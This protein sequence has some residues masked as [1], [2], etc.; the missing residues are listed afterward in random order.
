MRLLIHEAAD[1]EPADR[2]AADYEPADYGPADYEAADYEAAAVTIAVVALLRPCMCGMCRRC[3]CRRLAAC[4][5]REFRPPREA[6]VSSFLCNKWRFA[7]DQQEDLIVAPFPYSSKSSGSGGS[8][9]LFDVRRGGCYREIDVAPSGVAAADGMPFE[10]FG[11][12][13]LLPHAAYDMAD[14]PLF[15]EEVLIHPLQ[16]SEQSAPLLH[17]V[18]SGPHNRACGCTSLDGGTADRAQWQSRRRFSCT[19]S[20]DCFCS[21]S[22]VGADGQE[23]QQKQ[24]TSACCA[25]L[26]L[27]GWPA[28]A[29]A[30]S[31][32]QLHLDA[33]RAA[34]ATTTTDVRRS[35]FVGASTCGLHVLVATPP[36]SV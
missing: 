9:L 1:Y 33:P 21:G 6:S 24:I 23:Q 25:L 20:W 19:Y 16:H 30:T 10:L 4:V 28:G 35:V 29:R 17:S 22:V 14:T 36:D 7:V 13:C 26:R 3:F 15:Q 32:T 34:A 12:C 11:C 5:V 8:F 27:G 31:P 18:S 2:E